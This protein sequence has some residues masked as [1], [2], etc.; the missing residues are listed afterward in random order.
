MASIQFKITNGHKYWYIV[1]SRRVNGKP[2][3]IM[4]EYLG[5][6]DDL[7]K[8]LHNTQQSFKLK[9]YSHGLPAKLLQI[10]DELEVCDILNG[11]TESK[12]DYTAKKPIRNNMTVGATLM[13][14]AL[15]R[16]CIVTSKRGWSEWAKTTSLEYLLRT[17]FAKVDCQHFWD[18]MDAFPV[19][20]ISDAEI[21]ILKNTLKLYNINMDSLFYDTTNFYTYIDTVNSRCGIAQ[22]GKNKQKRTDLRQIGLAL[23]VTKDDMTPIFHHSYQGNLNDSNVFKEVITKIKERLDKLSVNTESHTIVFD[24]GNNSKKNLELIESLGMHYTGALTPYHHKELIKE[25]SDNF[26]QI[27]ATENGAPLIYRVKKTIWGREMTVVVIISEKLKEGQIRGLYTSLSNCEKAIVK[28]N[29]SLNV[30]GRKKR[31]KERIEYLLRAIISKYKAQNLIDFEVL[32]DDDRCIGINH[33]I[34]YDS[35]AKIEEDMGFRIIMTNRHEWDTAEIIKAYHGQSFIENTFKNMKNQQHLSFNPQFH[36]TDHKIMIHN[37]ICVLGYL[38]SS[39]IYKE[40]R[41]KGFTGSM[42]TLLDKLTNIRLGVM[43]E[44]N[45]KRGNRKATYMLEEMNSEEEKLSND[46][47]INELHKKIF[48]IKGFGVYKK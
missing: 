10:A 33:L 29:A 7:L 41:A 43:I 28:I 11:F 48:K 27:Y 20:N 25:A 2:R 19:E 18:A 4:L 34:K 26:N 21:T 39:L 14:G 30:P 47:E 13:L 37:F 36:W 5:K 45:N 8:R 22:R 6:P 32:E 42:D 3:P 24:R 23:V 44:D 31:D 46:L 35:L 1:E 40:A 12:R 17:S 16:T 9:S 38:M 15:G